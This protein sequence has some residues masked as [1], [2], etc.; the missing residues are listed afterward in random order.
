MAIKTG[1]GFSRMLLWA[2]LTI[3]PLGVAIT[4]FDAT[5][6]RAVDPE[7]PSAK[8]AAAQVGET[9]TGETQTFALPPAVSKGTTVKL[10]GA[11][12]MTAFSQSLKQS[13]EGQFVGAAVNLSSSG[14]EQALKRLSAGEI[15]LAAIARSLTAA[16]KAQ[17]FTPVI[18]DREKIAIV[19]GKDNPFAGDIGYAQFAQI[20][21]G[22]I[23]DWSALGGSAGPIRLIDRPATSDTRQSLKTYPAF[24]SAP[25]QT[26]TTAEPSAKRIRQRW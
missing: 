22:E 23:K 18:L 7:Q 8:P 17:G 10:D 26:G 3:L 24:Q 4:L 20:F 1:I 11:E 16:E 5:K 6:A 2:S 13:Y 9:Q 14:T 25:F 21:R 15:D 19:V 12:S